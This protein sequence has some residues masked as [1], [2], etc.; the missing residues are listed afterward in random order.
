MNWEAW[1]SLVAVGVLLTGLARNWGPPDLLVLIVLLCL[2]ATAELTN[3]ALL[4]ATKEVVAGLSNP[5]V[6][7]VGA[8]FVVVAG[9]VQTGAMTRFARPLIEQNDTSIVKAQI[10][11]I[12]PIAALSAFL[13]NTPVVAMFL[14]VVSDLCRRTRISPSKM[15]MPLSVAATL[16]G[17]CTL[18]GTST[19]LIVSGMIAE[20]TSNGELSLFTPAW[21]GVP[22]CLAGLMYIIVAQRWL[23][24]DRRPVISRSDDPREYSVEMI[25]PQDSQ[26]I[27]E[28]IAKAGLRHLPGLYLIEIDRND[29]IVPAV[30]SEERLCAGDRLIF[31]GSVESTVELQKVRGLLPATD[32]V[33]RLTSDHP[34]RALI[35]VVVSDR[36]PLN[37][38][39]I[40]DGH[41]RSVYGAAVIAVAR[42]GRRVGG[43]IGNI[44]LQSGDTLLLEARPSFVTELR[45]SPDFYLVSGVENSTILRHNRALIAVAILAA[46]IIVAS[47]EWL[48]MVTASMLAAVMMILSGCCSPG[49]AHKSIDWSVLLVIGGSL[50]IG[51]ALERSGAAQ[52]IA[53]T[54]I[55][56]AGEHPHMVLAAVYLTTMLFTEL[57]TNN[58]AAVLVFPI[59]VATA[60]SL[61]LSIMPFAMAVMMAA[62]A[63]FATPIGYQTSLMV[64]GPGGYRF[65][66]YLR[67][68]IPLNIL[69]MAICVTL[70]PMVWPF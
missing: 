69:L 24:P 68:G 64:F 44:I 11:L 30:S 48:Q 3:S 15:Y 41:F 56:L 8:L 23:L 7:T 65:S 34:A 59:A 39:S 45:D 6:I 28:S 55:S 66:D 32:P 25:V 16:G 40:R 42:S 31:V 51:L 12:A 52:A 54:L 61:E 49:E 9:L 47:M 17:L 35:E 27:G 21:V 37:G 57:I 14:P 4:P 19:N 58:A 36:C 5:A 67:F 22:C 63:A 1:I 33:F 2:I 46:L 50:G 13:N 62:S 20:N 53:T 29:T 70:I 10:R 18:I 38:S 26:L 43:R 60:N